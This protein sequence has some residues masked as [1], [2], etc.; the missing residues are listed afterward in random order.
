M[1]VSAGVGVICLCGFRRSFI[2]HQAVQEFLDAWYY[3]F[4]SVKGS[5]NMTKLLASAI[6]IFPIDKFLTFP[7]LM[8]PEDRERQMGEFPSRCPRPGVVLIKIKDRI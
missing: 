2:A 6:F 7:T 5:Y 8:K 4:I 3:G 1:T